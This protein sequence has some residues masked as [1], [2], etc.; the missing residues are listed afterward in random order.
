MGNRANLGV[1][2]NPARPFDTYS[3]GDGLSSRFLMLI[4]EIT[5]SRSLPHRMNAVAEHLVPAIR[6]DTEKRP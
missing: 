2:S 3:P 5:L 6:R 1:R 4:E